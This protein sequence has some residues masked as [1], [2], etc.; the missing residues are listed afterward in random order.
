VSRIESFETTVGFPRR[1]PIAPVTRA[2]VML[3]HPRL[4]V[5]VTDHG[6][7]T[8]T[9]AAWQALFALPDNVSVESQVTLLFATVHGAV[10][11]ERQ[12]QSQL[13]AG[14]G[15]GVCATAEH[16]LV[17]RDGT[18]FTAEIMVWLF[19]VADVDHPMAADAIWQVRDV[20]AER[21]LGLE[22]R[23]LEDYHRELARHQ[24]DLTF[25][26]DRKGRISYASPS[27]EDAL[28]HRVH[29]LLGEPFT[30]FLAPAQ[31]ADVGK[32][33]RNASS[34]DPAEGR[35]HAS[36][37]YRLHVLDCHGA[38]R[39]LACRARNCFDVPRLA[40]MV[41]HARDVTDWV[42]L[43]P[44]VLPA[45]AAET[46][47][48]IAEPPRDALTGLP[49][50]AAAVRW[51]AARV[52]DLSAGASLTMLSIDLDR[53][54][55]INDRYGYA[56]G[57]E[58]IR[59][60]VQTLT[61]VIGEG[62]YVARVGDDAFAVMLVNAGLS[63]VDETVAM[64]LERIHASTDDDGTPPVGASIGVAR[65]PGDAVDGATLW[66]CAELAMREAKERGRGQAYVFNPK[67]AASIRVRKAM[68]VE[69]AEALSRDEFVLFYQPQIALATG[70]VVG[71]EALVRWQHPTR[72]LLLPDIFI[73]AAVE[74]GLI[75]AITKSV[76]GQVCEQIASWRRDGAFPEL[77]VGINVAGSQFHDR[78]LPALVASALM[79]T[80]LPAR[81]LILELSEQSR[82]V[83]AVAPTARRADQARSRTRHG[84]HRGRGRGGRGRHDD[85]R[86]APPQ[87]PG[88]V[89]RRRDPRAVRAV[90]RARL[91]SRA[92]LLLRR[93]AVGRRDPRI[94]RAQPDV[95][96]SMRP[97][98]GLASS[99]DER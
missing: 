75:E 17:R 7:I 68:D 85:R 82:C 62:G 78:R 43:Q 97:Q 23:E 60:S 13:A 35:G 69:I 4:A 99:R 8:Q 5:A 67:L 59:R 29:A 56:A 66:Q 37:G 87:L 25:V 50:R 80:G 72:G 95:S 88:R 49:D 30:T 64:I 31:A 54:Q 63:A 55:D 9:N 51:L 24:W 33:L 46:S 84:P 48:A 53:L 6:R 91:R 52:A 38:E 19:D 16:A 28:G 27:I 74:R 83:E 42:D 61:S 11:F 21:A 92:R 89:R 44:V 47:D 94:R 70:R 93:A 76:V 45:P 2:A 18:S 77:P 90:A 10:R 22:L 73:D 14:D 26:I 1:D 40:G 39:V 34:R 71:L 20:S 86:G 41:V 58:A 12:L 32:W 81:L 98:C 3:E 65:L 15:Q 57:D 79:R 36:D 96:H